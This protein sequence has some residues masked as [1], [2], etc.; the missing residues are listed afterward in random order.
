MRC[1]TIQQPQSKAKPQ[2]QVATDKTPN[3]AKK[4]KDNN[5]IKDGKAVSFVPSSITAEVNIL[6]SELQTLKLLTK[7]YTVT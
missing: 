5:Y 3:T 6:C 2:L 1:S 4:T 7:N